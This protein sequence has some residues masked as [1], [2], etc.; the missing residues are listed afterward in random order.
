MNT[1]KYKIKKVLTVLLFTLPAMIPMTAF[2]I[3]PILKSSW[4][5]FTDWDY[6]SADYSYVGFENYQAIF[7]D[8]RF[9]GAMKVTGIFA[10]GTL[11]LRPDRTD[12]AFLRYG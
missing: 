8:S 10:A 11:L 5:S 1:A 4:L 12:T 6:M 7:D 3:M 2:W 9:W